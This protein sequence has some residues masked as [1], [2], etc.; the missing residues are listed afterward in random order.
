M[1]NSHVRRRDGDDNPKTNQTDDTITE[2]GLTLSG[3]PLSMVECGSVCSPL[4]AALIQA[5]RSRASVDWAAMTLLGSCTDVDITVNEVDS[6]LDQLSCVEIW[7]LLAELKY[8]VESN[9][10]LAQGLPEQFRKDD[11]TLY[12]S[13]DGHQHFE[14]LGEV[15]IYKSAMNDPSFHDTL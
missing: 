3:F 4:T 5:S 8:R 11:V 10:F 1:R 13:F 2:A 9:L 7:Y 14:C 15:H 12:L 6:H